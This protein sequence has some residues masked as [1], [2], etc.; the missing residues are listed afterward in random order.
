MEATEVT[1]DLAES[2]GS[3]PLGGWLKV[4]CG[5]TA[6][7]PESAAGHTLGK[8]YGKTLLLPLQSSK[9]KRC[10]F[11]SWFADSADIH[12][13]CEQDSCSCS[14]QIL[15]VIQCRHLVS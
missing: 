6:C 3:L 9:G 1:A 2:D 13:Y 11:I 14:N 12:I 7:T 4:T 10:H 5:L 8:E 15:P